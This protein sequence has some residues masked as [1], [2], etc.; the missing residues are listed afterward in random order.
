MY[1]TFFETGCGHGDVERAMNSFAA[2]LLMPRSFVERMET[3]HTDSRALALAVSAQC[4]VS[5]SATLGH[6]A[7]LD[8]ITGETYALEVER[9]P[10]SQEFQSAGF[11]IPMVKELEVVPPQ[12]RSAVLNAYQQRKLTTGKLW[13]CSSGQSVRSS[14]RRGFHRGGEKPRE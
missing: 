3:K 13:K 1:R 4:G 12:Y 11:A 10:D 6:L 2:H 8:V 14:C 5:W 7:N 9:K